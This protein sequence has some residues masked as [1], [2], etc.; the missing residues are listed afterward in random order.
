V[1]C[2][3]HKQENEWAKKGARQPFPCHA[4]PKFWPSVF[5]GLSEPRGQSPQWRSVRY[6]TKG[7]SP[8]W[9]KKKAA[10]RTDA[11]RPYAELGRV[12]INRASWM[13]LAQCPL[14]TRQRPN[15]GH[16][17]RSELCQ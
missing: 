9:L 5:L 11:A 8:D 1:A 4:E 12:L 6:C 3:Q 7:Q 14:C 16:C 10:R 13:R 17:G 2:E 15:S